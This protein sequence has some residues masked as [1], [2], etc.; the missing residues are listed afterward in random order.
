M[1][2]LDKEAREL[3]EKMV[4]DILGFLLLTPVAYSLIS[5]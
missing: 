3:M 4:Y 2:K 1:F 5:Q